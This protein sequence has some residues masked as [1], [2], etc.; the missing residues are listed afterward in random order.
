MIVF[1]LLPGWAMAQ[2]YTF[3]A[4]YY[5]ASTIPD[6]LKKDANSVIRYSESNYEVKSISRIVSTLSTV[7]T[8]LN[9][10]AEDELSFYYGYDS[11][12]SYNDIDIKVY[13]GN[14]VLDKKYSKKDFLDITSDWA[15]STLITDGRHLR[16]TVGVPSYP[17]TIEVSYK[18]TNDGHIDYDDWYPQYSEQSVQYSSFSVSIPQDQSLRIKSDD[19]IAQPKISNDGE[20]KKYVWTVENLKAFKYEKWSKGWNYLP[21]VKVSPNEFEI[22]NVKGS[23]NNWEDFGKFY[24]GLYSKQLDLSPARELEIQNLTSG[25]KTEREKIDFLYNYMQQNMR[26]LSIQLGIGGWKPLSA[27]YVDKNKYGDCKALTNYMQALLKAV[28][29]TSYPALINAGANEE[30]VDMQFSNNQFNHVILMVPQAK[31]SVW[32]ECTSQTS[33]PGELGNFTENR[34][35]LIVKPAGSVLISTP[36]SKASANKLSVISDVDIKADGSASVKLNISGTGEYREDM[37]HNFSR[38]KTDEQQEWL[39]YNLGIKHPD[40]FSIKHSDEKGRV[41]AAEVELEYSKLNEFAAGSKLFYRSSI[42]KIWNIDIPDLSDRKTDL[43]FESPVTKTDKTVYHLPD[44][45]EPENLPA[46]V[47][48]QSAFGVF[49]NEFSYDESTRQVVSTSEMTLYNQRIKAQDSA[50]AK[51]FFDE[52]LKSQSRRMIIRKKTT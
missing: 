20:N 38:E 51:K 45:Y 9:S 23:L 29:I 19:R 47:V 31:D 15:G 1:L 16:L 18:R 48:N 52:V 25:L 50:S 13:D 7:T 5:L 44:G 41:K 34:N 35:A 8:L 2:K 39:I 22:D 11:F 21:R 10:Q 49:K 17:A 32:L 42:Q 14:G 30:R 12:S 28:N 24:Y 3:P 46:K 4:T 40:K 37:I 33:V 6:S 26:Y 36:A 43:F 27:S